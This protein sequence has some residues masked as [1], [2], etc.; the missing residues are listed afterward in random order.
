M[1]SMYDGNPQTYVQY[2]HK[3][4]EVAVSVEAVRRVFEHVPLSQSLILQFPRAAGYESL[5]KD[6]AE[7]G[8]PC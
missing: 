6:A 1:L 2:A 3:Y 7:I 4:F 8:Y 5:L